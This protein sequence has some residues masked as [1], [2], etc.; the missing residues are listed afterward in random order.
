MTSPGCRF[1]RIFALPF[2]AAGL[3]TATSASAQFYFGPSY[4]SVP[5]IS[6]DGKAARYKGWV[7]AE[8]RYWTE[9]PPLPDLRGVAA[10]KNDLLFTAPNAPIKGPNLLSL[11]IDK[12]SPALTA[13][14]E[15]CRTG[16][17]IAE[18]RYAEAADLGR[19]PQEHGPLPADVPAYFEFALTGVRFTCPTAPGAPE[20]A[21]Q[22]HFEEIRW[23]NYNP[24]PRPIPVAA[25]PARLPTLSSVGRTKTFA[26]SW[27]AAA[28]SASDSQCPRMNAKPG[29][30][31]Y[32]ALLPAAKAAAIR[33]E[34]AANGVAPDRLRYRGPNEMDVGLMPGI[35]ADPGHVAARARIVQGF[36]LDGDDGSGAP[37][38]GVRKHENFLSPDGRRGID[39]QLFTVEGCVEGLRRKGFLPMI[40]NEGRAVGKPTAMVEVSGIDDDRND[41]QVWV[42]VFYSHDPLQ[43]SPAKA[44]LPD[45]TYRVS[46]SPE[47][48]QDF[49]RFRG[50]IVDGVVTT[51]PLPQ[52]H[53]HEVTGIETT[54][55]NPRLR[56]EFTPDGQMKG[57]IGGYL[58]WRKRLVF[59]IYRSSDYEVT[60]GYQAPAI[61]NA[62]KR[63][64]DGLYD[65]VTGDFTGISAAFEIEGVPAFVPPAQRSTLLAHGAPGGTSKRVE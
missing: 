11:S 43:R 41:A 45:F 57:V 16:E 29:S 51:D 58:D 22:V 48:T 40:F 21:V 19:H 27:F 34:I 47:Y 61:Y 33:A 23:L 37:P 42:T 65:P 1:A 10:D 9:R 18:V 38:R 64:A 4:I 12:H 6:G 50:R 7:R 13:M 55:I 46:D 2:A 26:V 31:D 60:V 62:M 17:R 59:Q 39:N 28:T 54:F 3:L 36:D 8:S 56:L 5:G 44:V 49:V 32:F 25:Q 14:L 35:V 53:I 30:D 15:R 52:L 24:Q 20:Q 63:A